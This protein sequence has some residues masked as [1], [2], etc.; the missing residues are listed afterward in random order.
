MNEEKR[1][2][3]NLMLLGAGAVGLAVLT[4][5]MSLWIYHRSGDVYL[6]RSRPG[7]LPDEEEMAEDAGEGSEYRFADSGEVNEEVLREYLEKLGEATKK[8]EEMKEPFSAAALSDETLGIPVEK[9]SKK[10]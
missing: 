7:F 8:A 9:G 5:A 10:R 2:G 6:D 1:G 4:T 3:R